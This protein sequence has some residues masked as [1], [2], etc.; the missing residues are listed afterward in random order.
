MRKQVSGGKHIVLY[1]HS[2]FQKMLS[3]LHSYEGRTQYM[4]HSSVSAYSSLHPNWRWKIVESREHISPYSTRCGT[5]FVICYYLK[6]HQGQVNVTSEDRGL[7][8]AELNS[9]LLVSVWATFSMGKDLYLWAY[10][11]NLVILNSFCSI[12][13]NYHSTAAPLKPTVT[14]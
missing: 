10:F 2:I 11:H 13:T 3:L 14:S 12:S 6:Y 5:T 1:L 8:V 7:S 4:T 9:I